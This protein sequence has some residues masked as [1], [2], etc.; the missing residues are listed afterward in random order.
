MI[1]ILGASA[2]VGPAAVALGLIGVRCGPRLSLCCA[3]SIQVATTK[4]SQVKSSH[5]S[6]DSGISMRPCSNDSQVLNFLLLRSSLLGRCWGSWCGIHWRCLARQ[7]CTRLP[8][9]PWLRLSGARGCFCWVCE[10]KS[11]VNASVFLRG[12]SLRAI[13]ELEREERCVHP[14]IWVI[15]GG[16]ADNNVVWP[17][18]SSQS[19]LERRCAPRVDSIV[20]PSLVCVLSGHIAKTQGARLSVSSHDVEMRCM[21]ASLHRS[22]PM[23]ITQAQA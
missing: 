14:T 16:T 20:H 21:I 1:F 13:R 3:C 8:N 19:L 5:S 15:D 6:Q 10:C 22:T 7:R 12:L 17:C 9:A 4:S 11:R 18:Q 2:A 23:L